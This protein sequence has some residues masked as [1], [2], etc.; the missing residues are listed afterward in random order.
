[1]KLTDK[2]YFTQNTYETTLI[3]GLMTKLYYRATDQMAPE[4]YVLIKSIFEK[5]SNKHIKN[6]QIQACAKALKICVGND[7][8]INYDNLVQASPEFKKI[9]KDKDSFTNIVARQVFPSYE[10]ISL[11]HEGVSHPIDSGKSILELFYDNP[12]EFNNPDLTDLVKKIKDI[13]TQIGDTTSDNYEY[14]SGQELVDL[15]EVEEKLRD[16]GKG[17]F[18]CGF[19][20]IDKYLNVGFAPKKITVIGGRTG[21][22]KCHGKG[23]LVLLYNGKLESVENIRAGDLLMGP[24]S[25]PRKVLSTMVGKG[26]LYRVE[27]NVGD[28]YIV[29]GE[30]MLSLKITCDYGRK[31]KGDVTNISV[32]DYLKA[33]NKF[34]HMHKGYKVGVDFS[35][36]TL[37]ID[38]Y[39]LGLWLGDGTASKAEITS[40]DKEI[41]DYLKEYSAEL[42]LTYQERNHSHL[43]TR[44]G[45][46]LKLE[47][48]LRHMLRKLGVLRNKHIPENYLINSRE[49]RLKLL[50]G[51][52]DSDGHNSKLY[53]YEIT[54]KR[55]DLAEQIKFLADSLGFKTSIR[56]KTA[57]IKSIGFSC[58]VYRVRVYGNLEV[59]PCKVERKKFSP[60]IRGTDPLT[61]GIKVTPIGIG[62]YYGFELDGDHLYLLKDLT[63]THNSALSMCLMKNLSAKKIHVAE[64]VIEMDTVSFLDRYVAATSLVDIKKLIKERDTLTESEKFQIKLA[65]ERVASHPYL[66]LND[67]PAPTI[68]AIRDAIIKLQKKIG[69]KYCVVFIDL[70]DKIKNLQ[71]R[72]S[73]MQDNFHIALNEILTLAKE[74]DVHFVLVSQISRDS[75]KRTAGN[76]RPKISELKHSGM[77]EEI[78]D[79]ILL[80]DRPAY[81]IMDEESEQMAEAIEPER[82]STGFDY[83][84]ID[85]F[86]EKYNSDIFSKINI[87]VA[88]KKEK[89]EDS[90]KKGDSLETALKESNLV[91]VGNIVIPVK[92]YAEVI[93]AKQRSGDM[94]KVIPF[95]YKGE[96]SLFTSVS[97]VSSVY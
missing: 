48:S 19:S 58:L 37:P 38:P 85:S 56:E 39:F 49:N 6:R 24:D 16:D 74:L 89:K 36:S 26:D 93:L 17:F 53:G 91:K 42:G 86:Q 2:I 15:Y 13:K 95:I 94:N 35:P 70:F 72:R 31:K 79:M 29:N 62:E 5:L 69:Q 25:A 21:M 81:R 88:D 32:H 68:D 84:S 64:N 14:K 30:H 71:E 65:K 18:T 22:G 43:L 51:L 10:D 97:L 33:N 27:Q 76:N 87:S 11:F 57:T 40:Y 1:M 47:K 96:Y 80:V 28:P 63:V 54:Q 66:H 12:N 75:E 9:C 7:V 46:G 23:T 67:K 90:D 45:T 20:A 55:K 77:W 92:Q 82:I 41:T 34:R 73:G 61:T 8:E 44:R 59:I 83:E 60:R 50:A 4:E 78:A 3:L 52:F